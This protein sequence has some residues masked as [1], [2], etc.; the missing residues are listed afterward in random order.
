[1]PRTKNPEAASYKIQERLNRD[2]V[3]TREEAHILGRSAVF[4]VTAAYADDMPSQAS[5]ARKRE[6]P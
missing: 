3:A 4:I 6:K 1:M 2:I 5:A